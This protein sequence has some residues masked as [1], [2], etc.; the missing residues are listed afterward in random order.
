MTLGLHDS[1]SRRRR[2]TRWRVFKVILFLLFVFAAG[3]AAYHSGSLIADQKVLQMDK[4]LVELE[5]NLET[6]RREN[7]ELSLVASRAKQKEAEW[8]RKYEAEVPRD[9]AKQL[10]DQMLAKLHDGVSAERL[11]FIIG[12]TANERH[13]DETPESKRFIV[14]TPLTSG[15][16]DSVSF[17]DRS[18]T[19][20]ASGEPSTDAAGKVQAWYDPALPIKLRVTEIGGKVSESEGVLPLHHSVVSGDNEYRFSVLAGQR[21][22]VTVSSDRCDFP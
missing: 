20:T 21:G 5:S 17:A 2:Q 4:Q 22:F 3:Y 19:V 7:D 9:T 14:Q 13:C 1:R 10:Y 16:N 18:L 8:R 11:A 12:A 15:A 6:V